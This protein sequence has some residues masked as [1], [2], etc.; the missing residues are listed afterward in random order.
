MCVGMSRT[1]ERSKSRSL[2]PK[3]STTTGIPATHFLL[4]SFSGFDSLAVTVRTWAVRDAFD[5]LG[6]STLQTKVIGFQ[7]P[8]EQT[9]RWNILLSVS[10][11]LSAI[12]SNKINKIFKKFKR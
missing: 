7:P 10:P 11:Y 6:M 12:L 8:G 5:P 9:S 2:R 4:S 3:A 1:D